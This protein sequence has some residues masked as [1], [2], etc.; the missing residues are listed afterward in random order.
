MIDLMAEVNKAKK[1]ITEATGALVTECERAGQL[2]LESNASAEKVSKEISSLQGQ[3]Q[4][5]V[6]EL[7][8]LEASKAK[9]QAAV[10]DL[11]AFLDKHLK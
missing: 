7:S 5:L 3:K 8:D 4:A 11:Q 10:A 2:A 1:I 6:L 9:L